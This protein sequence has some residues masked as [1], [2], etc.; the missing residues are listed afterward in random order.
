MT[1]ATEVLPARSIRPAESRL[2]AGV[3]AAHMMS[4]YYMLMLAPLLAFIRDDFNVSYTQLA[5]ALTVFNVVSGVLQTPVGFLVDRIGPRRV[6]LVGLFLSSI[7]YAIAGVV[8]SFWVFI[9]MYG[10]AGL[11]NTVYHPADYTL[12]SRHAPTDRVGQVFSYHTFAG[13]VGS[14]IAPVTLLYM[15]SQFGWRGAYIG[16]AIFGLIVLIALVAQ[17][18]PAAETKHAKIAAKQQTDLADTGWRL[19]LSP[20]ILLNLGFFVLISLMGSGLNTYLVVALGALHG[21]P[22]AIANMA[23]TALLAMSALGVLVGGILAG[24]TSRHALV[25]ASGL[26][27][28][29]VVTALVG[30]FDFG[31]VLLIA[32]M[33]FSGFCAGITYPSRDMLVRAVT[34]PGAFGKV[35]GFV[36]TGFNIGASIAPIMYGML[37][38]H[39]QPRS[40]FLVSAAV[41]LLCVSTVTI[42]F[43]GRKVR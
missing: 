24:R 8:G 27:V 13:M 36:S 37:M 39:G 7:S 14:A 28:G 6:L 21:T 1:E 9:A 29:G 17:P 19:L 22:T 12:L 30:L 20:P 38:D 15:Q 2:I 25:A 4:H 35:F 23:L 43:G 11:G 3:C 42:G 10:V 16:A 31:S 33:G 34:P 40:V 18:E 5:L 32:I 41:S 26:T